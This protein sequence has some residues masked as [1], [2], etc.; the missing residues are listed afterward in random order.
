MAI[1]DVR[2][3]IFTFPQGWDGTEIPLRLLIAPFG[4]PLQPLAP[5]LEP[6]A[7]ARLVLSAHLIPA[8]DQLPR[9]TD[10]AER[11]RLDVETAPDIDQ[12]YA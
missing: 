4:N 2:L 5:G 6:F 8:A 7:E 10:V 9:S 11:I 3:R 12:V 1:A